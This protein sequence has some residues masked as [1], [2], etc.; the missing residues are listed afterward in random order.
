MLLRRACWACRSGGQ[1]SW[2]HLLLV[3][4]CPLQ[5][6]L[7][8]VSVCINRATGLTFAF[9]YASDS[10]AVTVGCPGDPPYVSA[11][12]QRTLPAAGTSPW[13]RAQAGWCCDPCK[14]TGPYAAT[15]EG[16]EEEA[17]NINTATSCCRVPAELRAA[18]PGRNFTSEE[19]K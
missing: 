17:N 2:C 6:I 19:L 1:P 16:Y 18:Y 8:R 4:G 12:P 11:P 5:P 10:V 15:W 9:Q 14:W 13:A 7:A 3:Q